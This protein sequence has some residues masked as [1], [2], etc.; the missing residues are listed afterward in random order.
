MLTKIVIVCTISSVYSFGIDFVPD[1]SDLWDEVSPSF[2]D[3]L[4]K[5][6]GIADQIP[7]IPDLL[8]CLENPKECVD[9]AECATKAAISLLNPTLTSMNEE[10]KSSIIN[11]VK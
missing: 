8:P 4:D 6:E 2:N 1:P 10:C 7:N 3:V 11:A 5:F 9:L